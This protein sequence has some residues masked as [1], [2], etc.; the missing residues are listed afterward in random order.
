MSAVLGTL[1]GIVLE[2]GQ[3]NACGREL[4][5]VFQVSHPDGTTATYGRRCAAKATGYTNVAR[6]ARTARRGAVVA[7]RAAKAAAAFPGLYVDPWEII[8][9][10]RLWSGEDADGHDHGYSVSGDWRAAI[11]RAS[12]R[13]Y[14]IA[15]GDQ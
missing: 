10:D 3:C 6:A 1:T 8:V 5:R 2:A 9:N 7:S 11:R 4:G 15:R 12:E 14:Y 13:L